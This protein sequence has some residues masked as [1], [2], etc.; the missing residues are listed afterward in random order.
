MRTIKK[1]IAVFLVFCT[2]VSIM[3]VAVYADETP[4]APEM[5]PQTGYS[6][7]YD[8][9]SFDA[10]KAGVVNVNDYLGTVH[11]R[12]SDLSLDGLRLPINIEFYYDPINVTDMGNDTPYGVGW[13][14]NY[15]QFIHYDAQNE[16]F[17]Y[18]NENGTWIYF[19]DS[20]ETEDDM[21]IWTEVTTYEIGATDA[22][23]YRD[24]DAQLSDLTAVDI[25]LNELHHGFDSNGRMVSLSDGINANSIVYCSGA[26]AYQISEIE[27]SVGRKF[28]FGYDNN[29][30]LATITCK[31]TS[32]ATILVNQQPLSLAYQV[33]SGKLVS[34]T[35]ANSDS[36]TYGYDNSGKLNRISNIDACGFEIAYAQNASVTS[37]T[38]KAAMGTV[39][40]ASGN[41]ATF[42]FSNNAA[43]INANNVTKTVEFDDC[44]RET[45]IEL[46]TI[47][48]SDENPTPHPVTLF[49]Y[50]LTYGFVLQ[51]N[52]SY[53]NELI[54]V[55]DLTVGEGGTGNDPE[56]EP[57]PDPEIIETTEAEEEDDF[58]I[59]ETKDQFGNVLTSTVTAGNLSQTTTYT[60]SNDG[61][62]LISET[63]PD[64]C[65]VQY[66]YNSATGIL[67]ALTDA[68]GNETEYTYNAVRELANVHLDVS[69]LVNG[70][71]MEASYTYDKGRLSSLTYGDFAYEF[72]YDVWGNLLCVEMNDT[73][74][75]SYSYGTNAWERQA[76]V[77]TYGNGNTVYYTYDNLGMVESVAY[78]STSNVRFTYDYS[79]KQL[80]AV[81]DLLTGQRTVYSDNGYAVYSSDNTVLYS[82]AYND[83]DNGGY[84]ETINGVTYTSTPSQDGGTGKT[85]S[86]AGGLSISYSSA[87][88]A[89]NRMTIKSL[90][91]YLENTTLPDVVQTYTYTG[92]RFNAG[93]RVSE[94]KV[95]WASGN[96][97]HT[98]LTMGY[99]YDYNG[100]ITEITQT[101]HTYS[102]HGGL[103]P[104]YPPISPN[105]LGGS[106]GNLPQPSYTV[107]YTYDEANQLTSATDSQ[108]GL[109]YRY[110]YDASGNLRTMNTYPSSTATTPIHAKTLNYTDGILTGYSEDGVTTTFTTDDMGS[111]ILMTR[112]GNTVA[113]LTWG[114]SRS[115]TGYETA[116]FSAEYT[117]NADGLRIQKDVT[118]GNTT[119]TTKFIWGN[120]GLAGTITDNR[121]V[122]ILYDSDGDSSGFVL[123]DPNLTSLSGIYTYVK[124][125]QGDVLR[126]VDESGST[127]LSYAY[128]PW[129]VQTVTG[130]QTL[131]ELNPCTYRGYFYDW[132]TGYYYLESRYYDTTVGR[133]LN[134]DSVLD[135]RTLQGNNTFA[136]CINNPTN[137]LDKSGNY[138]SALTLSPSII[139]A[140]SGALS[141]IMAGIVSS[142]SAIKAAIA[143]SWFIPLC[144]A[145]AAIAIV[146]IVYTVNQFISLYNKAI[147][148]IN[149]VKLKI[150]AGGLNPQNLRQHSVYVIYKK[151]N[152]HVVYVG[153]TCNFKAR[154]NRHQG[155]HGRYPKTQY[156]MIPVATGLTLT[157]ARALEQ[158]L[159]AAFTLKVLDNMI[160]SVSPSKWG[161]FVEAAGEMESLIMSWYDPE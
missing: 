139:A 22:V 32:G 29:G 160:N 42:S 155:T 106:P 83:D 70:N 34:V 7:L 72:T 58:E 16:Q 150:Q 30:A 24:E 151:T 110:T 124:N 113:E 90:Q 119:K 45:L 154:Q 85:V 1:A 44:G 131:A 73:P 111:P 104:I 35:D 64:G 5:D 94:Y 82:I 157:Q 40:E 126:V 135:L 92:T 133:F 153:R 136:Y 145:A 39:Q 48:V 97:Q 19:E 125:P 41:I 23:L 71:D 118:V 121:K 13:L 8:Y 15:H 86:T 54:N 108:T 148:T 55:T 142:V 112:G 149:A 109:T 95:A 87:Y 115:L 21:E 6:F 77:M 84:T 38:E 76:N 74:L 99:D 75:V 66:D 138:A 81:N 52:G 144:V 141:G 143:T 152:K 10:G 101:E 17:A 79:D 137:F 31:D 26:S 78:G 63:D 20:G 103:D 128:D 93:N 122:T 4:A 91:G 25:V 161:Q 60:Y 159:I 53:I 51:E 28:I 114:E 9:E 134:T 89:L 156:T 36:I 147:Q 68:N 96:N 140:L 12:R 123:N 11:L 47:G 130:N 18:K 132:E 65:T 43:E 61:N 56:P 27:D 158:T 102:D 3:S 98:S 33:S 67:Q 120:N 129:G 57:E 69:G 127:V 50:E 116:D 14:T 59:S 37:V 100:N 88:D 49:A 2:L 62:Y 80:K 105:G 117:Y 46:T 107:N 146:A